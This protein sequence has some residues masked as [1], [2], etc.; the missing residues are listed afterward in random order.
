MEKYIINYIEQK[1]ISVTDVL[2]F[3][4]IGKYNQVAALKFL[5]SINFNKIL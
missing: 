2:S 4:F 3:S 1:S 5:E